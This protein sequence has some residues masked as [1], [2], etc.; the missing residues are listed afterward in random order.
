MHGIPESLRSLRCRYFESDASIGPE[1]RILEWKRSSVR[2]PLTRSPAEIPKRIY[3]REWAPQSNHNLL[4]A[5]A[6]LDSYVAIT[7][8]IAEDVAFE[9]L[10]ARLH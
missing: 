4:V 7:L 10:T 8:V 1:Q 3:A 6:R 9:L 2:L 5:S